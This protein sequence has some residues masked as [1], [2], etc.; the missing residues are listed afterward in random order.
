[1]IDPNGSKKIDWKK[2]G[3]GWIP[4]YPDLRDF[5][6]IDSQGNFQGDL[7][8][9]DGNI[10][11]KGSNGGFEDAAH[12]FLGALK[13]IIDL[14]NNLPQDSIDAINNEIGDLEIKLFG[15]IKFKI[16]KVCHTLRKENSS[17]WLNDLSSSA[18]RSSQS[19]ILPLRSNEK[20]YILAVKTRLAFFALRYHMDEQDIIDEIL[21]PG[22]LLS[23]EFDATTEDLVKRFQRHLK[24]D[25][26]DG[27][28]GLDTYKKLNEYLNTLNTTVELKRNCSPSLIS[29]FSLVPHPVLPI[30]LEI[31]ED[32]AK[33]YYHEN[34]SDK[35]IAGKLKKHCLKLAKSGEKLRFDRNIYDVLKEWKDGKIPGGANSDLFLEVFDDAAVVTEPLVTIALHTISPIAIYSRNVEDI[36][37]MLKERMRSL[38]SAFKAVDIKDSSQDFASDRSMAINAVN[39]MRQMH[40]ESLENIITSKADDSS[41]KYRLTLYLYVL[42][43]ALIEHLLEIPNS[44]EDSTPKN[45][46]GLLDFDKQEAFELIELEK[47]CDRTKECNAEGEEDYQP[48]DYFPSEY[49]VIPI[50]KRYL[51]KVHADLRNRHANLEEGHFEDSVGAEKSYLF[52]PYAVD[53]SYW[54][55]SIEDQG[56]LNA[57]TSFA[58][59]GLFEYFANRSRGKYT[60]GS[61]LFLYKSARNLMNLT[62]DVGASVRET[63][64]AIALFGIPPET[65]W[66]YDT[67][68]V[69]EEPPPFCYAYAQSYQAL[70]YFRLDHAGISTDTLLLQVKAMLAA[71]FPSMFGFTI[72]SSAYW[73]ENIKKGH[74]P[75]PNSRQDKVMG[76]H[77]VVAVGYDDYRKVDSADSNYFSQGAFLIRNSWGTAWG[78]SGYGWLPYDYVLQGFTR[79]WWSILKTEWFNEDDFGMGARG[80][81]DGDPRRDG[82]HAQ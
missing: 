47:I 5:K 57:C 30:I 35:K 26:I 9:E 17:S 56:G 6:L 21:K 41:D 7:V 71:G 73:H 28:I 65:T 60:D 78:E 33:K 24:I 59:L 67:D 32:I 64:K 77:A 40:R 4:D 13:K 82:Q 72:Y 11:T 49:I 15:D 45:M 46:V 79:D 38:F 76:G 19:H 75:I 25:P 14:S 54:C 52:L 10:T 61:A 70:K 3:L 8:G 39:K 55:S 69:D 68:F 42:L 18:S 66:P 23:H 16:A 62:G 44:S 80:T 31:L 12:G 51:K 43:H 29:P 58:G 2:K 81:G 27:I 63:M 22:F 20:E 50:N 74:I 36:S 37:V 53:L 34:N 48:V 1:M